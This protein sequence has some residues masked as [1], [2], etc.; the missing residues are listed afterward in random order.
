[1]G[2]IQRLLPEYREMIKE[3]AS[4]EEVMAKIEG[5]LGGAASE[6][7]LT[8][9]AR[10]RIFKEQIGETKE[11]IGASLL[12]VIEE[13]L[14]YLQNLANW[15]Q[16]N[17]QKFRDV[18]LAIGA[19]AASVVALNAAMKAS[20]FF[21]ATGSLGGLGVIVAAFATAYTAIESF[22]LGVNAQYNKWV[23]YLE[24]T[25]NALVKA[26]NPVIGLI[27]RVIPGG[28]PLA[29]LSLI[30]IP[31]L[32]TTPR[33][34]QGA[35]F[36]A[37]NIPQMAEGGIVK[38]SVGGTLAVIGEGGQDEAVIP[39]NRLNNYGGGDTNVTIHVQGADPNAVVDALR[40]YMFRNG[41]V[42]IRVA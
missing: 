35:G 15:A 12:P 7:A 2:A 39:L 23:G 21:K 22:Q 16:D 3:G 17:P 31:R 29:Q 27:N 38:A 32:N 8:A 5:T 4:F 42:P 36:A 1:M 10:F 34:Q 13:V 26:F 9:E 24:G 37:L 6:A 11:A 40:T 20:I 25:V 33:S 30:N 18:A 28:N 41:S 19:I 14:P